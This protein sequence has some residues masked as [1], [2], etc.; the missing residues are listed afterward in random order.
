MVD[1][2]LVIHICSISFFHHL[3]LS[4]PITWHV[5]RKTLTSTQSM[6]KNKTYL[7][8]KVSDQ[9]LCPKKKTK[10]L[11]WDVPKKKEGFLIWDREST[12]LLCDDLVCK[13]LCSYV[14]IL[15]V[16]SNNVFITLCHSWYLMLSE[17][18]LSSHLLKVSL[19]KIY[20]LLILK[21]LI[22]I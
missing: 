5:L 4:V 14:L 8:L 16:G 17:I 3:K 20:P 2:L 21:E 12:Y 11:I 22:M 10:L 1:L 15:I 13:S 19:P 6:V 9:W 7:V 18:Q